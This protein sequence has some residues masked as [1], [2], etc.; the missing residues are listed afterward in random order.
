MGLK[1]LLVAFDFFFA[2]L[3]FNDTFCKLLWFK[4]NEIFKKCFVK[5][6]GFKN[7]TSYSA[8]VPQKMVE[9]I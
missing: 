7:A 9:E 4:K 2:F 3:L 5:S 8:K 1:S 6:Q